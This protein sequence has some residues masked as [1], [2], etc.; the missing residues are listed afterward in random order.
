MEGLKRGGYWNNN[1]KKNKKKK[2]KNVKR[3]KKFIDVLSNFNIHCSRIALILL[4]FCC[5]NPLGRGWL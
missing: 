3:E 5:T 4:L 1:W 2:G